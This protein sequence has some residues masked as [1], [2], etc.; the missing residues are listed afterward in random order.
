[1]AAPVVDRPSVQLFSPEFQSNPHPALAW[2]REHEP[3]FLPEDIPAYVLTRYSDVQGMRDQDTYSVAMIRAMREQIDGVNVMQLDGAEHKRSRALVGVGFRPR[4]INQFVGQEVVPIID[5]LLDGLAAGHQEVDLN[6]TFCQRVP[7]WSV[8]RLLGLSVTEESTLAQLYRDQIA[9]TPLTAGPDDLARSLAAREGLTELLTPAIES[10][11]AN[12]DD[13]FLASLIAAETGSGDS[14]T[15]DELLGFLRFLLPAGLETTMSSMSNA[16]YELRRRPG[17]VES[18]QAAPESWG[19]ALE[20][21]IRWHAPITYVNR[22][23]M[24]D[25]ELHGTVIP[26]GS[27]VLGSLNSANRDRLV[28]DRPDEFDPTRQPNE[29]VSFGVGVHMCIGAPLAR[30]TLRAALPRLFERFPDLQLAPGFAG[31]YEGVFDNRL[32]RLPVTLG[33]AAPMS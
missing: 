23:T 10:V 22:V 27:I 11:R 24:R 12:P 29:H 8:A 6:P 32:V 31:E 13:S 9:Y 26:A 20:E 28:F 21:T 7:F 18:L 2:Y 19:R 4:V 33:A 17:L 15:E 3:V 14:L 25:V 5:E 1:M 30:A 16:I